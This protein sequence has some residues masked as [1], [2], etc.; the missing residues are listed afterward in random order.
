MSGIPIQDLE[1]ML[2]T[3]AAFEPDASDA[4]IAAHYRNPMPK[5]AVAVRPPWPARTRI[6]WPKGE[7]GRWRRR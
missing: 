3:E 1:A 7:D 2:G 5:G 6:I 4:A